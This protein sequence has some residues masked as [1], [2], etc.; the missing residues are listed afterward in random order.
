MK[1]LK[2]FFGAI[3]I[4]VELALGEGMSSI[5]PKRLEIVSAITFPEKK[6]GDFIFHSPVGLKMGFVPPAFGVKC[7]FTLRFPIDKQPLRFRVSMALDPLGAEIAGESLT[8]WKAPFGLK[9]FTIRKLAIDVGIVYAVF[10]TTGI[11]S[12]IGGI[13]SFIMPEVGEVTIATLVD[14]RKAETILHAKIDRLTI[15]AIFGLLKACGLPLPRLNL[16]EI[17]L[18]NAELYVILE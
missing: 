12:R 11:P 18:R 14:L 6:S 10:A 15:A 1:G 3:T 8:E 5:D 9:G 7:E 13:G 2:L 4:P 16:P 17:G